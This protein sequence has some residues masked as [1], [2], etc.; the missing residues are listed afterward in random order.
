MDGFIALLGDWHFWVLI[1]AYYLIMAVIGGMPE[2]MPGGSQGY[3]WAYRTLHIFA[4]NVNQAFGKKIP[5][6]DSIKIEMTHTEPK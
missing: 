6:S 5:G 1:V 4:A 2:P 3:M